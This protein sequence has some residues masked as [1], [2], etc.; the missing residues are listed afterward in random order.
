MVVRHSAGE[1]CVRESGST[2][3]RQSAFYDVSTRAYLEHLVVGKVEEAF[4]KV[5]VN[6][7]CSSYR[8]SGKKQG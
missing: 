4:N 3:T 8:K 6:K 5:A 2:N 1:V 7:V